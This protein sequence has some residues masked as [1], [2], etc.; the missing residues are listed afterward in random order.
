MAEFLFQVQGEFQPGIYP[1]KSQIV[2][3]EEVPTRSFMVTQT[4]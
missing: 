2:K 1:S 3:L 4:L